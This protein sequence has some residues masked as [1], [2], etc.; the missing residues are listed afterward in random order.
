MGTPEF[1]VPSLQALIA[2]EDIDV[3]AVITQ[4]DKATGRKQIISASPVKLIAE[5]HGIPVYQPERISQDEELIKQLINL[6]PDFIITAA[7]GQILRVNI[8][9]I[10]PVVNL[11]AS[12][13]SEFRGPAPINWMIIHG[14]KMVGLT[15]MLTGVGVDTGDILLKFQ[16]DLGEIENAEQLTDRLAEHGA[17]L[18]L[19]TLREFNTLAPQKQSLADATRQLAPFMDK[20]LG[21]I[22]FSDTELI[23]RSA[24]P[25]QTEF[26]LVLKN[27]AQN[28][29]NLVRATYPWPGAY[30]MDSEQKIIILETRVLEHDSLNA[31][32]GLIS[33]IDKSCGSFIVACQQ[34]SLE[35]LKLKPQGKNAMQ[36]L[37]WLNGKRLSVGGKI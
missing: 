4:P 33:S 26:K 27:S 21:R 14:D 30:F 8:L 13:L 10:A 1:A 34:G 22:N 31:S 7:Y 28:I 18:L 23:L 17:E 29:H 15:T 35:I 12:L 3:L 25:K 16:T 9:D 5:A 6:Q 11:H 2:A 32:P 37:D 20:N 19:K 24:N 36:A